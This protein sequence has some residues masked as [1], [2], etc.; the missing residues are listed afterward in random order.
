MRSLAALVFLLIS[1]LAL[2]QQTA[3]VYETYMPAKSLVPILEPLLGPDDRITAYGNKLFVKAPPLQQD[4]ILRI[5]E[6]IDRPLKNVQISLRYGDNASL[7]A[8]D[9]S[10]DGKIVVYKGSSHSS[11]VD[12]EVVSKNRFTTANDKVDH[13]IRVLEGEQGMIEVGQDVPVDQFVFISPWQAGTT[14]E[15]RSV[16]NTL[17]V[18][19]QVTKDR[20]RIEVYTS[21]QRMKRD[22]DNRIQKVQAQSVVVVEPGVWTPLAGS[23]QV[24]NQ[25]AN[26][27]TSSTRRAGNSEKTLQIRADILD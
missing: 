18:V 27:I 7:E 26:T 11:K 6:E 25:S 9:T 12:V 23:S 16:S 10:A 2:A 17:Y 21:N 14:K 3:E 15:Y 24:V 22:S 20:I 1:A 4:E 19:P 5:L 13:Q 8:Q